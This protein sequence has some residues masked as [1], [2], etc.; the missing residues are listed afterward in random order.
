MYINP[1]V[2]A[3]VSE[4]FRQEPRKELASLVFADVWFP[5][6]I[7]PPHPAPTNDLAIASLVALQIRL[8]WA[9]TP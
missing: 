6:W 9:S 1:D 5:D 2:W 3:K 7:R 8:V 4:P